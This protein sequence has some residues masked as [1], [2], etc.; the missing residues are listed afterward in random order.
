LLAQRALYS[1][2][3][4]HGMHVL[5]TTCQPLAADCRFR[6]NSFSSHLT[7]EDDTRIA[8]DTSADATNPRRFENPESP[9]S[10]RTAKKQEV[11]VQM[12][13]TYNLINA[14][15]TCQERVV[16]YVLNIIRYPTRIANCTSVIGIFPQW[17]VNPNRSC[18]QSDEKWNASAAQ[19]ARWRRLALP[20]VVFTCYWLCRRFAGYYRHRFNLQT[21]S[22]KS[23]TISSLR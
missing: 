11:F 16:D 10:V 21:A 5:C 22:S 20:T 3:V 23:G 7:I 9:P 8:Q 6:D 14:C 12:Q 18:L 17:R 13:H 4:W 19:P 1:R 15:A 2:L